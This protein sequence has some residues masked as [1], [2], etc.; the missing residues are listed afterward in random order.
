V[1]KNTRRMSGV[2]VFM[3]TMRTRFARAVVAIKKRVTFELSSAWSNL[4]S[5]RKFRLFALNGDQIVDN[6][7]L[8]PQMSRNF[9]ITNWDF[10]ITFCPL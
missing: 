4:I 7:M 5:H 9:Y 10:Y 3:V 8:L 2:F 6:T 1:S